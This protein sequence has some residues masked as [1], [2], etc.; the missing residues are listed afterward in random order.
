MADLALFDSEAETRSP[1]D[2]KAKDEPVYRK[3]IEYLFAHSPFYRDKLTDAGFKTPDSVGGL[4]DLRHLPF[5]VK[6]E[7]RASQAEHLPLGAHLAVPLE[8]VV[9]VYSTSGTS[10]NPLYIPVTANDLQR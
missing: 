9:R 7:L 8:D 3:Q 4:D 5:T 6:D 10:R 1:E 2:Q